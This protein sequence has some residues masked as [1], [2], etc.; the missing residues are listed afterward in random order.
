MTATRLEIG[1]ARLSDVAPLAVAVHDGYF[2]ARGLDVSL[3]RFGSW[4]SMRDAL[5]TGAISAAHMLSPMIV[6]SA[7]GLGPFPR[8]FTTSFMFNLNGNAITVSNTLYEQMERSAPKQMQQ[9]PLTADALKTVISLRKNAGEPPLTF[10]HVFHYSMHAYELRYWLGAAGI[11]PD[12]DVNLVVIS[13]SQMVNALTLGDIDGFCVGEP[14]NCSAIAG[15]IGRTLITSWDIWHNSPEKVLAVRKDWA[16]ENQH[17]HVTLISALLEAAAWVDKRENRLRAA[18]IV[19]APEFVDMP[20]EE[21]IGSLTGANRQI[22][23]DIRTDITDFNVF[24]RYAANFPWQS[25]AKWVLSQMIRW[26]ELPADIDT[27]QI[28]E[29]AFAPNIFRM[30]AEELGIACP[31]IN[32]K[33]EG[34]Q[35]H[36]WTLHEA[37]QPIAFGADQFM[38]GRVFDP[39][40][41]EAYVQSFHIRYRQ[42]RISQS[43]LNQVMS[44]A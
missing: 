31:L 11:D 21:V 9:L 12:K 37:S 44:E 36:P 23:G 15:G 29:A 26:G 30:A 17:T 43:D 5:G 34:G 18:E 35:T 25:Q 40:K 27:K 1:F 14:W 13:P 16:D 19:S 42:S 38:D 3:R 32:E 8:A 6:A 41:I 22:A 33:I 7:A 24:H 4:A 10:A 20:L 28:S 2:E 39:Q